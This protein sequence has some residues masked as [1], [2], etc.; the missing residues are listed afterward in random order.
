MELKFTP[1]T[2]NEIEVKSGNQPFYSLLD[3]LRMQN[4]GLFVQKGM[5][6][7]TIEDAYDEMGKYFID[8]KGDLVHLM[9]LIVESLQNSGFLDRTKDVKKMVK[10]KVDIQNYVPQEAIIPE[11]VE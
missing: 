8:E 3:N 9:E 7:K 1:R 11:I 2:V 10:E 6:L 4:L 5:N